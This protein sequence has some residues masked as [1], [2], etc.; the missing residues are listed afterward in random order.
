MESTL[1]GLFGLDILFYLLAMRRDAA[2]QTRRL[3]ATIGTVPAAL[4]AFA[5]GDTYVLSSRPA[6]NTLLL[7][8]LYLVSAAVMGCFGLALL[9]ARTQDAEAPS[10][11]RLNHITLIALGL[12]AL[13]T[14]AYLVHLA[15]AP[16]PDASRSAT[17]VLAGN[18]APLFW[19]GIVLVGLLIPAMLAT[20]QRMKIAVALSPLSAA[21]L[22]LLC[23]LV[24]GISFRMMMFS[25][26]SSIR[27]FF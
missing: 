22:G 10:K 8:T 25:L 14:I 5:V 27:H 2:A 1:I 7:P 6:W 26:G 4:L 15:V 18:L 9:M 24:A 21:R 19:L 20:R 17:R 13:L 23:V 11:T 16:Y 12:Q 3:I